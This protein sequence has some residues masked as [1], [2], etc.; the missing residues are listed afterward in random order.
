MHRADT[1]AFLLAGRTLGAAGLTIMEDVDG[2]YTTDPQGADGK[3][4][5]LIREASAAELAKL[6]GTLPLDRE[7]LKVMAN[8][9]H[10]ER[11][12]VVRRNGLVPGRLTAV[13]PRRAR[14]FDHSYRRARPKLMIAGQTVS[15]RYSSARGSVHH[16][17][18][19][20]RSG[21]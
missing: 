20:V 2:V 14:R 19:N 4:A 15:R 13:A 11:V 17:T 1:G 5:Q 12:Q 3:Q 8:A 9:Q 21:S 18:T 6:K 16:S 7:L 10:I